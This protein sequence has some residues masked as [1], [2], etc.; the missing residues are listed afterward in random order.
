MVFKPLFSPGISLNKLLEIVKSS[1]SGVSDIRVIENVM[2]LME[3][4]SSLSV[5]I[6]NDNGLGA[7]VL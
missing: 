1:M 5:A 6:H 4:G 2:L 3:S 7:N